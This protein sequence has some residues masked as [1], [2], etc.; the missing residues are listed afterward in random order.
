MTVAAMRCIGWSYEQTLYKRLY[1]VPGEPKLKRN[2]DNRLW[3]TFDLFF[4]LRGHGWSWSC[5]L[6]VPPE[7]RPTHS[8][9]AFLITT[10]VNF[11]KFLVLADHLHWTIQ[12]FG[13]TTFGSP[14]GGSIYDPSLPPIHSFI[15]ANLIAFLGG[16]LVWAIIQTVY[17]LSTLIGVGILNQHPLQ[18]PPLFDSPWL[19]TSLS[20]FWAKRWHQIFRESFISVGG[21]PLS[22]LM[23]RLGGVVGAFLVS[24]IYHNIGLW[25]MGRGAEFSTAGG[26]FL[27]QGLG[28]ILEHTWKHFTGLRVGGIAGRVWTIGWVVMWGQMLLDVWLRKGL[29]AS[30]FH[31]DR[32]RPSYFTLGPLPL[33]S[34]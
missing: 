7:T 34:A 25:A 17:E 21:K 26:F 15:R 31:R 14:R 33:P 2:Q 13:P 20:E 28:V 10:L 4:N 22:L 30:I 6:Y 9:S 5:G 12:W 29:G 11:F 18:W 19:S 1:R 23:G 3:D 16:L 27:V 32:Y 8:R 24:A